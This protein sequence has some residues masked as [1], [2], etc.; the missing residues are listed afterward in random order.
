MFNKNT[1]NDAAILF[2]QALGEFVAAC[3]FLSSARFF[4]MW[5]FLWVLLDVFSWY[6]LLLF[7]SDTV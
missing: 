4:D 7:L 5:L 3:I 1:Q 2:D 6:F